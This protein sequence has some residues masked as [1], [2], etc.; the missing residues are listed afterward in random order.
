MKEKRSFVV[1]ESVN[2][3]QQMRLADIPNVNK[4][5]TQCN[6]KV[7]QLNAVQRR[8]NV[9]RRDGMGWEHREHGTATNVETGAN[10]AT[11]FRCE[12]T[13]SKVK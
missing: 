8:R 2:C 9:L 7:I 10:I 11:T 3:R 4:T 12:S 13:Q 5:F 1:G 6:N